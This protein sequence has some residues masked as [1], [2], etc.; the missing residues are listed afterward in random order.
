MIYTEANLTPDEINQICLSPYFT[1]IRSGL[2]KILNES[3]TNLTPA[4][5][6]ELQLDISTEIIK[7]EKQITHFSKLADRKNHNDEWFSR[8]VYKAHKRILKN[9]AD[10]IAWRYLKCLRAALRLISSH[11]Q[12]G[13]ISPG[14]IQ[15]AK[16]AERIVSQT[17][18]F[19]ILNDIT[20]VLRYGDL[21][22]LQNNKTSFY[23][24]KG[25]KRDA[26]A[27]RQSKKLD[28][29]LDM[30]NAKQHT[31]GSQTAKVL[32]VESRPTHF[33]T[34][35]EKVI[36]DS[37][38]KDNGI[39]Y[40]KLSPYLWLSSISTEKMTGYYK[41]DGKI[42]DFPKN[43]FKKGRYTVPF[44][45]QILFDSY[46]PNV[47]PYSIFPFDEEI[48]IDVL[49]GRLHIKSH[50]SEEGLVESFRGKG[51][52]FNYP[53]NDARE[54]W[55]ALENPRDRVDATRNQKYQPSLTKGPFTTIL[56]WDVIYRIGF[57]FLSVKSIIEIAEITRASAIPGK[58]DFVVTEF[59]N[60]K[61]RWV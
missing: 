49:L 48:I 30:L 2:I 50:L 41:K 35:A 25:G 61:D 10:G 33:A 9:I 38:N 21:T 58:P 22:I 24:V 37:L 11:N 60:E 1:K 55:L 36:V 31:I 15:E 29:T 40:S 17:G 18:A 43:P 14:F 26:R 7:V 23:E 20:N 56:P 44:I 13:H 54:E 12:T 42:P 59:L 47:A 53:S 39:A 16:E 51:W 45:N 52:E 8:E 6:L 32:L 4:K 34:A 3:R 46:S 28:S 57:E 5:L 19:V 27:K